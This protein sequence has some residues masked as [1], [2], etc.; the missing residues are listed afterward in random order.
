MKNVAYLLKV[1]SSEKSIHDVELIVAISNCFWQGLL[2]YFRFMKRRLNVIEYK[3]NPQL[4]Q[5][6]EKQKKIYSLLSLL[7]QPFRMFLQILLSSSDCLNNNKE[8]SSHF[9]HLYS[10]TT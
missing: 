2:F 1:S 8:T 10:Q 9:S 4:K 7:L 6:K 5:P 3:K